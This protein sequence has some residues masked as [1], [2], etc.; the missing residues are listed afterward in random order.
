MFKISAT[1]SRKEFFCLVGEDCRISPPPIRSPFGHRITPAGQQHRAMPDQRWPEYRWRRTAGFAGASSPPRARGPCRTRT[2]GDGRPPRGGH[3]SIHSSSSADLKECRRRGAFFSRE[4]GS[5][6][7]RAE[8]SGRQASGILH[9]LLFF[10][11]RGALK[12]RKPGDLVGF[13]GSRLTLAPEATETPV[14]TNRR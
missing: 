12:R 7:S 6:L 9:D 14:Y 2:A 3:P 5:R 11:Y 4:S 8:F 13:S 1:R 10:F